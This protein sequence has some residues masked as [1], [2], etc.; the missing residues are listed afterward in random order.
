M[1]KFSHDERFPETPEDLQFLDSL[2]DDLTNACLHIQDL[3]GKRI[4][5]GDAINVELVAAVKEALK[6]PLTPVDMG[7]TRVILNAIHETMDMVGFASPEI[8]LERLRERKLSL[9][10]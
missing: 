1:E 10:K 3:V 2:P 5:N 7:A 9:N 6:L 4:I 8:I